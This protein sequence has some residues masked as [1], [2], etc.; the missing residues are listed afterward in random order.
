MAGNYGQLANRSAELRALAADIRA[1][2]TPGSSIEASAAYEALAT[3]TDRKSE[4]AEG[5]EAERVG[6]HMKEA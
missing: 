1:L 2:K 5:R 3:E 4:V 6:R